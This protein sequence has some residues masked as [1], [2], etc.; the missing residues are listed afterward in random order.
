MSKTTDAPYFSMRLPN[1][2]AKHHGP[3]PML[4]ARFVN[5]ILSI[6]H[7][8]P[9]VVPPLKH[10]NSSLF[11]MTSHVA[12][13]PGHSYAK[14]S[15]VSF[16]LY[17]QHESN[18]PFGYEYFVS[19]PPSYESSSAKYPLIL[20]LHGAGESQ[21]GVNE[22]YA[23]IRHGIPKIVLC[24]DKMKAGVEPPHIHIP[25]AARIRRSKQSEAGDMSSNPV[26]KEVCT[27][28]AENF[29]TVTPSLDMGEYTQCTV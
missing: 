1:T 15:S 4:K 27:I 25:Q 13:D 3:S 20:F 21:R 24:Y 16:N 22:S 12:K 11:N 29:I 10:S 26:S 6:F 28:V 23:S 19:L 18:A 7:I 9:N 14:T 5:G 8:P 17:D 2:S